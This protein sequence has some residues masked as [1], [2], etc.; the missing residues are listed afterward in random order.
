[1]ATGAIDKQPTRCNIYHSDMAE[2]F[3]RTIF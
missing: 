2:D 1:M 3:M